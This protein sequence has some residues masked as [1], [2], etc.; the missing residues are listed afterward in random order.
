MRSLVLALLALGAVASTPASAQKYDTT[1][2][3]CKTNYR[4]GGEDTDCSYTSLA[5]CKAVSS[6]LGA[7]CFDNPYYAGAAAGRPRGAARRPRPAY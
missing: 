7:I 2:P 3:V 4:F 6:G 1:S 5:Q